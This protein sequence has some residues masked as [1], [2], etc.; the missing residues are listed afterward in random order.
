M[1][2]IVLTVSGQVLKKKENHEPLQRGSTKYVKFC[3]EPLDHDWLLQRT[4]AVFVYKN[5]EIA[6]PINNNTVMLPDE[7][8][9]YR[10]FKMFL[11]S[12]N[13]STKIQTNKIIFEQ[14]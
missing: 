1:K 8:S 11:V 2:N 14:R 12:I 4:V 3:I 10:I 13:G 6:V 5:V 7:F 9:E